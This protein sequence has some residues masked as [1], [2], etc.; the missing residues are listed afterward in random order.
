MVGGV[1]YITGSRS[2]YIRERARGFSRAGAICRASERG[3]CGGAIGP[4]RGDMAP[5]GFDFNLT[6]RMDGPY[7]CRWAASP[8]KRSLINLA[9]V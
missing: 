5:F 4:A 6:T 7:L 2:F 3:Q 8:A 1:Y 9:G